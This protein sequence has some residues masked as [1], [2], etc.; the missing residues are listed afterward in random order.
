[1]YLITARDA[2]TFPVST[3]AEAVKK[4]VELES[5]GKRDV[6]ILAADGKTYTTEN[7]SELLNSGANSCAPNA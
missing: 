6:A 7:F 5:A 4:A 2:A 3:A 1:M